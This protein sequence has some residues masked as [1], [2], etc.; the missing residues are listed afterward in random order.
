MLADLESNRL[1]NGGSSMFVVEVSLRQAKCRC[2]STD[3]STQPLPLIPFSSSFLLASETTRIDVRMTGG[4]S[5]LDE[6]HRRPAPSPLISGPSPS[7]L[8][9]PRSPLP[10]ASMDRSYSN[11][12][13]AS[14]ST[15]NAQPVTL[16]LVSTFS[17]V[18]SLGI[19]APPHIKAKTSHKVVKIKRAVYKHWPGRPRIEGIR[20][21]YAGRVLQDE[22]TLAMVLQPG[23]TEVS[24]SSNQVR[25]GSSNDDVLTFRRQSVYHCSLLLQA[26]IHLAVRPDAWSERDKAPLTPTGPRMLAAMPPNMT[27]P[28]AS[29]ARL[30]STTVDPLEGSSYFSLPSELPSTSTSAASTPGLRLAD[31]VHMEALPRV[32]SISYKLYHERYSRLY[33]SAIPVDQSF[34]YGAASKQAIDEVERQVFKWRSWSDV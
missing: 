7:S 4:A 22:E 3:W 15:A 18:A 1:E 13:E 10:A 2:S 5:L 34:M 19:S 14:T 9:S 32:L 6:A 29:P 33:E 23:Q 26:Y 30:R 21:I 24:S 27:K 8:L 28:A 11:S 16:H 12:S 25:L 17:Y 20:L 31:L